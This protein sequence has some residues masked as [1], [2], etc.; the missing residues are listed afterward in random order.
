MKEGATPMVNSLVS[1]LIPNYN[2]GRYLSETINSVLSQSHKNLEIIVI[3]DGSTDNSKEVLEQF[4]D[5]IV[6]QCIANG[7]QAQ[8]RNRALEISNGEYIALLDADDLWL[9]TKIEKQLELMSATVRFSYTGMLQFDDQT[10]LTTRTIA[11]RF[12]GN[13]QTAFLEFP[14]LAIVPGGESSV[15]FHRSLVAEIGNFNSELETAAGRD[16]YRRCSRVTEF[17]F[18]N[19]IFLRQRMHSGSMSTNRNRSMSDTVKAY[20]LLF[21]DPDWDISSGQIRRIY[22]LLEWSFLK[23]W[24]KIFDFHQA[25]K[26]SKRMLGILIRGCRR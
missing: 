6:F 3:D 9:P 26:S 13:C 15:L 19:E 5:L 22:L 7:G 24:L 14:T 4:K 8:A 1:V 18:T 2:Y 23:T 20:D 25:W 12:E 17:A 16:F 11:P 10:G 21:K